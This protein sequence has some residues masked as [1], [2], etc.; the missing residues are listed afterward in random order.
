MAQRRM[1]SL[2]IVGSDAFM[3]M[4]TSS[5]ELYFQLGM[6]ADDDGFVNPKKVMRMFGASDDDLKVLIGK[7]FVLPFENGVVV[8]KHWK[9]NNL[10]RKDF[11]QETVY[12][13]QKKQI[14]TKENNAYTECSQIVNNLSPQVRLGKDSINS[15]TKVS[16]VKKNL[17]DKNN[18]MRRNNENESYEEPAI[19]IETGELINKSE[20]PV[21][22]FREAKI[23][24]SLFKDLNPTYNTW[25]INKTQ[26]KSA[27]LLLKKFKIE[28]IKSLLEDYKKMPSGEFK[29]KITSPYELLN[30]YPE[31][32]KETGG[33]VSDFIPL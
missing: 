10:I 8:I 28:E 15:E 25:M 2:K 19:D 21:S 22:D 23:V 4:P 24:F 1:F 5:R 20:K 12:L 32:K 11:Y 17:E 29:I 6:Y 31:I 27:T 30:K 13:E 16:Q 18:K 7:R 14:I 3:D 33:R 9:I 26:R